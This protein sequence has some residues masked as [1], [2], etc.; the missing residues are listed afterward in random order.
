M[1]AFKLRCSRAQNRVFQP[2][3]AHLSGGHGKGVKSLCMKYSISYSQAVLHDCTVRCIQKAKLTWNANTHYC[4]SVVEGQMPDEAIKAFWR[5]NEIYMKVSL[6]MR[7]ACFFASWDLFFFFLPISMWA[8]LPSL[9]NAHLSVLREGGQF[10][11][12]TKAQISSKALSLS[13]S[14]SLCFH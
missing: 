13:S 6:W 11:S 2:N 3:Y 10:I 7:M 14:R 12:W 4:P 9:G 1:C 5:L 8:P